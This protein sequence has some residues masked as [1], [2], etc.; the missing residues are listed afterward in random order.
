VDKGVL[1]EDGGM[2]VPDF[3]FKNNILD[4]ITDNY[5][6]HTG[7]GGTFSVGYNCYGEE[8]TQTFPP[9]YTPGATN[10]IVMNPQFLDTTFYSSPYGFTVKDG[11]PCLA[12][13]TSISPFTQDYRFVTRDATPTIGAFEDVLISTSWTGLYSTDWHDYRN[14][15]PEIVPTNLLHALIPNRMNDPVIT[16]SNETCKGIDIQSGAQVHVNLP[17]TLTINN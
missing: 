7:T 16:N 9:Y 11:S 6:T 2:P 15:N 8:L 4:Q 14:W 13:G 17:G 1:F 5:F 3:F 10:S 12:G